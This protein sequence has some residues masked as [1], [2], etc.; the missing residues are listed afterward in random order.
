MLMLPKKPFYATKGHTW[1]G[2]QNGLKMSSSQNE[3]YYVGQKWIEEIELQVGSSWQVDPYFPHE[4][5]YEKTCICFFSLGMYLPLGQ[6][7][8]KFLGIKCIILN[9]PPI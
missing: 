5:F 4:I 8:S 7:Y 1:H 9:S 3:S 2:E 6:S